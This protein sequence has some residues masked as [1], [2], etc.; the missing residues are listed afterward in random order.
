[1]GVLSF[2]G[3]LYM[4]C[5]L[6]YDF[7]DHLEP[8]EQMGAL[9]MRDLHFRYPARPDVLRMGSASQVVG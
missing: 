6:L 3:V 8:Q 1:M 9:V 5:I 4:Q 7:L 2:S